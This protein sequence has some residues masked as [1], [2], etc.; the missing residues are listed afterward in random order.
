MNIRSIH[1]S[2]L[3]IQPKLRL[4]RVPWAAGLVLA[5]CMGATPLSALTASASLNGC[6]TD[7]II[8]LTNGMQVHLSAAVT[9]NAADVSAVAYT[10]HVPTDTSLSRVVYTGGAL[11]DKE[12][13]SVVSDL[14]S[15]A[16][17]VDTT[18]SAANSARVQIHMLV[19]GS[20]S[21][22]M[23][24]QTGTTLETSI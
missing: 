9:A 20:G 18:V 21:A 1:P 19:P 12:V 24:G 11:A 6:R 7:P 17:V 8:H 13:V 16:Y 23:E 4:L 22:S 10:V 3:D 5:F 2:N 14:Q 15:G